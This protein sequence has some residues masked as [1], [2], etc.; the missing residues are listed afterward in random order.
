MFKSLKA[1]SL[2][3]SSLGLLAINLAVPESASA[4]IVCK[5][6][7]VNNHSNGSLSSCV[8]DTDMSIQINASGAGTF[9]VLCQENGWISF[10]EQGQFKSCQLTEEIE[11]RRGNSLQVCP[12]KSRVSVQENNGSLS[13]NCS[14]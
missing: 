10:G 7:T 12:A 14:R 5:S 2:I 9:D 8:L 1:F 6:G 4:S 13:V 11:I 3:T